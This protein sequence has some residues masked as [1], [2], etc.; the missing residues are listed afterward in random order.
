MIFE[1]RLLSPALVG[2]NASLRA[3]L[4][5]KDLGCNKAFIIYDKGIKAARLPDKIVENIEK[6]GIKTI[7]YDGVLPDPP[8]YMVEEAAEIGRKEAVDAIV[9]IGGGSTLDTAKAVRILLVNPPPIRKYYGNDKAPEL[10][11]P[12]ILIPT[13]AG[14]GSEVTSVAVLTN[15]HSNKKTAPFGKNCIATLA[16]VDPVLT[17]G[18]PPAITAATGMDAF[19][20]AAEAITSSKETPV[21]DLLAKEAIALIVKSLPNAVENGSDIQARYDMIYASMLAG[22]A[23]NDAMVHLG[24]SIAHTLGSLFHVHHG[25]ACGIALPE[26]I[27]HVAPVIPEKV[28][29][30]G[31]A[32][33]VKMYKRDSPKTIGLKVRDAIRA[34]NKTIGLPSLKEYITESD[35]DRIAA[36]SVAGGVFCPNRATLDEISQ[37][38][39]NAYSL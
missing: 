2:E 39:Y 29:L 3:G 19:S 33:G 32:M 16:I 30:V 25:T 17:L 27:S 6:L 31:I 20:H 5:L 26:V 36:D 8:D 34:F 9:A 38:L 1:T 7:H 14:T 4:R 12:L 15:T 11:P 28:K 10:G 13:T 18:M 37:M 21:S 23:F 24:H 35:I 22:Y